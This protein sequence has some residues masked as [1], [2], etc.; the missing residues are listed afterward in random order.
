MLLRHLLASDLRGGVV[1]VQLGVGQGVR[2][3]PETPTPLVRVFR[4]RRCQRGCVF[5]FHPLVAGLHAVVAGL[6]LSVVGYEQVVGQRARPGSFIGSPLRKL[7]AYRQSTGQHQQ[8]KPIKRD[9][10]RGV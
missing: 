4:L 5:G 2:G 8:Q 6:R 10:D 3:A 7:A 9:G 1:G